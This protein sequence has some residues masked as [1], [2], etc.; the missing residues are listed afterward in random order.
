[1]KE[2]ITEGIISCDDMCKVSS[3]RFLLIAKAAKLV[4]ASDAICERVFERAKHIGT[5]DLVMMARLFDET[6]AMLALTQ[7]N[8]ERHGGVESIEVSMIS[9]SFL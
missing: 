9:F 4:L 1:M 8:L 5:T 3:V 2:Y 7:Y 6:F